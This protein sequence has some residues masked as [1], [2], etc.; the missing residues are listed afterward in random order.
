DPAGARGTAWC[1]RTPLVRY[2][3]GRCSAACSPSHRPGQLL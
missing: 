1:R 3:A 2:D